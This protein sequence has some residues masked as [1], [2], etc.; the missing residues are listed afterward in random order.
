MKRDF[1]FKPKNVA[2][3]NKTAWEPQKLLFLS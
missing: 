3:P 1:L 2:Q